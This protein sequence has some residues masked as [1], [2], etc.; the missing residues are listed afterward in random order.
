MQPLINILT[1]EKLRLAKKNATKSLTE[2]D[3]KL[4]SSTVGNLVANILGYQDWNIARAK[5]ESSFGKI[6]SNSL[7]LFSLNPDIKFTLR[8]SEGEDD[9]VSTKDIYAIIIVKH[10]EFSQPIANYSP[11][12]DPRAYIFQESKVIRTAYYEP[13]IVR[14]GTIAAKAVLMQTQAS[15][16]TESQDTIHCIDIDTLGYLYPIVG[17]TIKFDEFQE[18]ASK[19]IGSPN[20]MSVLFPTFGMHRLLSYLPIFRALRD[21]EATEEDLGNIDGGGF[22]NEKEEAESFILWFIARLNEGK[23]IMTVDQERRKSEARYGF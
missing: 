7:P 17:R 4:S 16:L 21:G 14:T 2:L 10:H 13:V 9:E 1:F 5:L 12:S 18:Y 3:V 20:S 8:P 15:P 11:N 6:N 23:K 19:M 22:L